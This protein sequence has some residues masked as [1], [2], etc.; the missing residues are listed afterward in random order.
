M[1]VNLG[2]HGL[3]SHV[4]TLAKAIPRRRS[5][6]PNENDQEMGGTPKKKDGKP[7]FLYANSNKLSHLLQTF[8]LFLLV[9]IFLKYLADLKRLYLSSKNLIQSIIGDEITVH[10]KIHKLTI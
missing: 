10:A 1:V 3:G 6:V 2:F 7:P 8:Q 4:K 9:M 5:L